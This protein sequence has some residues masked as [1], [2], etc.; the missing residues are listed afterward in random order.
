MRNLIPFLNAEVCSR[1]LIL[2]TWVHF[3]SVSQS[4]WQANHC[5]CRT[6][7]IVKVKLVI[8][9]AWGHYCPTNIAPRPKKKKKNAKWTFGTQS[10]LGAEAISRYQVGFLGKTHTCNL[11]K[12]TSSLP[13]LFL[14]LSPSLSLNCS[15]SL[16]LDNVGFFFFLNF[17]L[18]PTLKVYFCIQH[19]L[20]N[21]CDLIRIVCFF[22]FNSLS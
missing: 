10:I 3:C 8:I 2:W 16:C 19:I 1:N 14:C 7:G 21:L 18:A 11:Y 20:C 9:N 12:I 13:F 17:P 15:F 4:C 5:C 6:S 22:P